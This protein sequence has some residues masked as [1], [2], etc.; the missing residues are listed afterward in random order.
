MK[1]NIFFISLLIC[2]GLVFVLFSCK[3]KELDE[4]FAFVECPR[5]VIICA[6]T[7]M[8][9]PENLTISDVR[10]EGNNL[11]FRIHASGCDGGNWLA[12]LVDR[13][14]VMGT[15]PLQRTLRVIFENDEVCTTVISRDFSFN[16]ECLQLL[17]RN[18]ILLNIAGQTVLY[19]YST[20]E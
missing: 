20:E 9:T 5:D 4:E 6:D 18:E 14:S 10:I 2:F 19:E 1:K 12:I 13:G 15:N 7:F 17:N 16:I 3:E 11:R 8:N